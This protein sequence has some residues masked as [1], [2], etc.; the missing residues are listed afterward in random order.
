VAE[1][2]TD[3]ESGASSSD[4][5]H[6]LRT[7]QAAAIAA[8]SLFEEMGFIGFVIFILRHRRRVGFRRKSIRRCGQAQRLPGTISPEPIISPSIRDEFFE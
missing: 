3:W 4:D 5:A 6:P 1:G 8:S 2:L 7:M